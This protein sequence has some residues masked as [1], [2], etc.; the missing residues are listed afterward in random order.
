MIGVLRTVSTRLDHCA[1]I[2]K[3]MNEVNIAFL[4]AILEGS[5][6]SCKE[7]LQ[8]LEYVR[9]RKLNSVQ[10]TVAL[11]AKFMFTNN[12]FET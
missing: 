3:R 11:S 4:A 12:S 10:F 9:N 2:V 6:P 1:A 8:L 7:W 5:A